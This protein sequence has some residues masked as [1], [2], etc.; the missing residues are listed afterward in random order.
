M[1]NIE[2]ILDLYCREKDAIQSF[3]YCN[4]INTTEEIEQIE[5]L[6]EKYKLKIIK[7]IIENLNNE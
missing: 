6:K 1:T 4:R 2:E 3:F 5:K 7:S